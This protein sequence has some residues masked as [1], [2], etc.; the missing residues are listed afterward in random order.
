MKRRTA[1]K[2]T[3]FFMGGILSATAMTTI[4]D[5]CVAPVEGEVWQPDFLS[6][7]Q[8]EIVTRIADILIPATDT[9]GAVEVLVPQFVDRVAN[10]L[11]SKEEQGFAQKGFQALAE[12]CQTATGKS[13]LKC[14]EAEQ[15]AFLQAQEKIAIESETPTLFGALKEMI[16]QGY[17]NS[18][19]GA[20][21]VLKYDPVPGNYDGCVPFSEINGTWATIR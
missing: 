8:G 21:E 3:A 20:T 16:Y 4:F 12:A 14:S 2:N 13:F 15:L 7:D 17:F 11:L 19:V 1:I 9:A 18:E 6:V 5:S 10:T